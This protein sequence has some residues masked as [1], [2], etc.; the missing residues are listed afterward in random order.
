MA[1]MRVFISCIA[2]LAVA[3]C[4]EPPAESAQIEREH[5]ES[6]GDDLEMLILDEANPIYEHPLDVEEGIPAIRDE[7]PAEV[8][9]MGAIAYM[10][11]VEGFPGW[12]RFSVNNGHELKGLR[13]RYIFNDIEFPNFVTGSATKYLDDSLC[14]GI[15]DV[16]SGTSRIAVFEEAWRGTEPL[17]YV[18]YE[19]GMRVRAMGVV[20][21]VSESGRVQ[22]NGIGP[23]EKDKL[24][25][26]E[27]S[28]LEEC[29]EDFIAFAGDELASLESYSSFDD[30]EPSPSAP[31]P[32]SPSAP[33]QPDCSQFVT[34]VL[35]GPGP[36]NDPGISMRGP[37]GVYED[38]NS[39]NRVTFYGVSGY[40]VGGSYEFVYSNDPRW[41]A[42]SSNPEIESYSGRISIP[43]DAEYCKIA[44]SKS[45]VDVFC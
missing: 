38:R 41:F 42:G 12:L 34:F 11:K 17:L 3:S 23:E 15:F 18:D 26:V 37:N 27:S 10:E 40:C 16:Y 28:V 14:N 22:I 25:F 45:F 20:P 43:N 2:A 33:A 5:P 21:P 24:R 13:G 9:D 32:S 7:V 8:M 36:D 31:Q 6:I 29:G 4:A 44:I 1:K 39:G 30:D 19:P 35:D